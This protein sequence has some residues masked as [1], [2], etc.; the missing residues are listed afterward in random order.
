M[1][2][3]SNV[4]KLSRDVVNAPVQSGI[5]LAADLT[6]RGDDYLS[7]ISR[8]QLAKIGDVFNPRAIPEQVVIQG[9][10]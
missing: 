2:L 5:S 4:C 1:G 10:A 8:T 7:C 6:S 9:R 3:S